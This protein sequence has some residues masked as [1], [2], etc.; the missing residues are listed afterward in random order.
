MWAPDWPVQRST[1]QTHRQNQGHENLQ[2]KSIQHHLFFKFS[3]ILS[4][5]FV[6]LH[7]VTRIRRPTGR[8]VQTWRLCRESMGSHSQIQ[9]CWRNGS[10]FRRRPR[11][12]TIA[13]L[14]KWVAAVVIKR[15]ILEDLMRILSCHCAAGSGAV[16]LPWSESWQL[17]LPAPWCIHLQHSHR[18]HQGRRHGMHVKS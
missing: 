6:S 5:I 10:V 2:G 15:L 18:V 16:F 13:R 1:C 14:A 17:L 3:F 11:I 4:S 7:S 8:A 9:R 12:E